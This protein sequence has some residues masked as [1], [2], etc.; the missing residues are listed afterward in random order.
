[1]KARKKYFLLVA[2]I[3]ILVIAPF[4]PKITYAIDSKLVSMDIRPIFAIS[5]GMAKD[6]GTTEY[7]G[8]GYQVI[9]WNR[10]VADGTE[11]GFEIYKAPNYRDLN[12][13]PTRKL[14]LLK[15]QP[16]GN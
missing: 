13:G 7:K 3:T 16:S 2:V 4:M 11:Y 5:Q 12:D 9:R 10:L 15:R 6:G 14:T 1:M 8:L